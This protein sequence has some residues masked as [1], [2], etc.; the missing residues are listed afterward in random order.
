MGWGVDSD[1]ALVIDCTAAKVTV[2]LEE[3]KITKVVASAPLSAVNVPAACWTGAAIIKYDEGIPL[4][5]IQGVTVGSPIPSNLAKFVGAQ[6][7]PK[8]LLD[9]LPEPTL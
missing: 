1:G 8:A 9:L 5:V 7:F 2:T 3:A 6:T 4:P